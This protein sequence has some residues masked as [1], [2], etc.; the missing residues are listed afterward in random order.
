MTEKSYYADLNRYYIAHS[1]V[2]KNS[3]AWEAKFTRSQ[4]LNFKCLAPHQEEFLLKA[5]RAHGEKMPDAGQMRKP[6]DGWVLYGATSLFVAIYFMPKK[7]EIYEMP[8]RKFLSE[9]Y[10]LGAEKS[11]TRERA[12]EIGKLIHIR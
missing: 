7:T 10:A 6:F 9:K 12:K 1:R 3:I 11:L 8:I 5:E 4:R 2:I